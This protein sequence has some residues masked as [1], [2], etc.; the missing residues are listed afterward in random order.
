MAKGTVSH[1]LFDIS[2][3]ASL[4]ENDHHKFSLKKKP[5]EKYIHLSVIRFFF[6]P[7]YVVVCVWHCEIGRGCT[8]KY[9]DSKKSPIISQQHWLQMIP[10]CV[11]ENYMHNKNAAAAV[12]WLIL[13][14]I[15]SSPPFFNETHLIL[16]GKMWCLEQKS[17]FHSLSPHLFCHIFFKDKN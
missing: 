3:P 17:R 13:L 10:P 1:F 6:Y 4:P 12:F 8:H 14:Y 5:N 9:F 16:I 15:S 2:L 7:A 11:N